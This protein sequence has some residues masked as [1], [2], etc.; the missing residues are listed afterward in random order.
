VSRF[1]EG[2]AAGSPT[3]RESAAGFTRRGNVPAAVPKSAH[4]RAK[5]ALSEIFNA[6]DTNPAR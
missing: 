5:A 2:V 4:P 6:E 3:A 1:L